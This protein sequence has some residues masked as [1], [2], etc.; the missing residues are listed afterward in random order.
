MKKNQLIRLIILY[1]IG[2][3]I[4][5]GVTMYNIALAQ[6]TSVI[7]PFFTLFGAIYLYREGKKIDLIITGKTK[8]IATRYA[9]GESTYK[10]GQDLEIDSTLVKREIQN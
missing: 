1:T 6:L 10:I 4:S 3:S 5:L 2:V 9:N 7:A 8:D